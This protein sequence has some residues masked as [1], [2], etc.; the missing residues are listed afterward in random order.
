MLYKHQIGIFPEDVIPVFHEVLGA[1]NATQLL[2]MYGIYPEMDRNLF[3]QQ[4]MF[5]MGDIF[6]S[7]E[8]RH[9]SQRFMKHTI[10][11]HT[12]THPLPRHQPRYPVVDQ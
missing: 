5:L 7:G 8:I 10:L 6:L 11:T 3:W 4:S 12:R 2:E 9:T 1:E